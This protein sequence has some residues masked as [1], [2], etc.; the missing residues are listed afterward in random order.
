MPE[1][2]LLKFPFIHFLQL[3]LQGNLTQSKKKLK[4]THLLL[5]YSRKILSL[6]CCLW[7][8]CSLEGSQFWDFSWQKTNA[9]R[10][11]L[12]GVSMSWH[13][14]LQVQRNVK[15]NQEKSKKQNSPEPRVHGTVP[16]K[17]E[18]YH[19]AF[20]SLHI[21]PHWEITTGNLGLLLGPVGT[22]WGQTNTEH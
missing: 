4:Q 19:I 14:P 21:S 18:T 10:K 1:G 3:R 9:V 5:D 2:L 16:V 17:I 8:L 15:I 12:S 22:F 13:S 6:L 20:S 7:C 11:A